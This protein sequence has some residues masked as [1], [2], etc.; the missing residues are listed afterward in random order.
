M[1]IYSTIL[2]IYIALF[3]IRMF[4]VPFAERFFNYLNILTIGGFSGLDDSL[5]QAIRKKF[6]VDKCIYDHTICF[7]ILYDTFCKSVRDLWCSIL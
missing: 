5:F 2:E 7:R 3:L 1:H 6:K 4:F